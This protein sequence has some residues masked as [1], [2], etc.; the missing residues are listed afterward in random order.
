MILRSSKRSRPHTR[1]NH[2]PGFRPTLEA[3]EARCVPTT[4][5]TVQNADDAGAGSLRAA[6]HEANNTAGPIII[7]MTSLS[8]TI[9]LR[10]ALETLAND[11]TIQ[12]P[13][14]G[15]LTVSRDTLQGNFRLFNIDNDSLSCVIQDLTLS[16]GNSTG[17]GSGGAIRNL[18]TLSLLACSFQ[19]DTSPTYGGAIYN[20]GTLNASGCSFY[21]NTAADSGGAI[22]NVQHTNANNQEVGGQ[23]ILTSGCWLQSNTAS[24]SGGGIFSQEDTVVRIRDNSE[25]IGNSAAYGGG[26]YNMGDLQMV[27]GSLSSNRAFGGANV[28]NGGQGGGYYGAEGTATFQGVAFDGNSADSQGGGFYLGA[29][30]LNLNTCTIGTNLANT[31]QTGPGGYVAAGATYNPVN[32]TINDAVV[33]Q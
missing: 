24:S 3:L 2:R 16:F 28:T 32:C 19:H 26:I 7:D 11:I 4:T 15:S 22:Y 6:V 27:G 30:T 14:S 21:Y 17:V 25:V 18:G 12:G 29:G 8:G 20:A 31:A 10:S 33:T 9:T 1:P 23:L 5:I 13:V